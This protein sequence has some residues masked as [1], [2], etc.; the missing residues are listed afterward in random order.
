MASFV[1][2][3]LGLSALIGLSG[4]S[5]CEDMTLINEPLPPIEAGMPTAAPKRDAGGG[6]PARDAGK[7]VVATPDNTPSTSDDEPAPTSP[8]TDADGGVEPATDPDD[9]APMMSE[10][11]AGSTPAEEDPAP[12]ASKIPG[13]AEAAGCSSY[14]LPM[15]GMCAG[16]YCGVTIDDVR[17]EL[18]PGSLCDPDPEKICDGGLTREVGKCARETKSNPANAF[19]TDAQIR[20]K[21]QACVL[22]N[23]KYAETDVDCLGCFLDAAQCASDNCL[24][25][26]LTGDSATCD[27]CRMDAECNQTVPSCAGFPSPF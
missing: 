19:D 15:G 12:Q 8:S 2:K 6:A 21:V 22:K 9:E 16:Y 13:S 26:C 18:K 11:D 24:T 25:Q 23:A 5:A 4:L 7:P 3:T 27:K 20:M 17:A 10:T 14:G 1:T